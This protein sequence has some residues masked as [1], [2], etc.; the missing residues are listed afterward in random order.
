MKLLKPHWVSHD[1]NPIYSLS[2]HPDGT[3]IATGGQG[4]DSGIVV[5][6]NATPIQF[7]DSEKDGKVPKMLCELTNHLGCV[8]CVKWSTDGK[9]LASSGDDA[10]IMLWQLRYKGITAPAFGSDKPTH[11]QWG[12]GFM[13]R[14]HIGDVLDISWSQDQRFLASASVDNTI[15]VWNALKFPEKLATITEHTGLVKGLTWDP[16]GKYLASQSDDKSVRVWRTSDWKQEAKISAPFKNCGGTTHVLRLSWS[17]DGRFIVSA[18]SL[19]NDGP[20]AHI[21][22]RNSWKTGMD[23]VGHRKAIEVVSFNPHL[24]TKSDSEADNHGCIAIGSRDR[25]LSIWLTSLKRPLVVVH[26]LFNNSILDLAWSQ[27]GYTLMACSLDGTCSYMSFTKEEIGT[28]LEGEAIDDLFFDLYG[29]KRVTQDKVIDDLLLEDPAMLNVHESCSDAP[30]ASQPPKSDNTSSPS[31]NVSS[32]SSLSQQIE[33][34][35]KDGRRRI[36]PITLTGQPSSLPMQSTPFSS[37]KVCTT[38]KMSEPTPIKNQSLLSAAMDVR[39]AIEDTVTTPTQRPVK[40]PP[41]AHPISFA[42]LSPDHMRKEKIKDN[43][44]RSLSAAKAIITGAKRSNEEAGHSSPTLAKSKRSKRMR[45]TEDSM[46]SAK[47]TSAQ[48]KPSRVISSSSLLPT[49]GVEPSLS[50]LITSP[51]INEASTTI[52]ASNSPSGSTVS[53]VN[54]EGTAW[55]VSFSSPVLALSATHRVT[56]V[57]LEDSTAAFLSSL[58]G[59]CTCT[60]SIGYE[61]VQSAHNVKHYG[62]F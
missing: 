54:E 11:E 58:T 28:C 52:E 49:P 25:S 13:L 36:T 22:E 5:I 32:A 18:H 41:Q 33:T 17:P 39:G 57:C 23:F 4:K 46:P 1:G 55:T 6:W 26:E 20:T 48:Q 59:T 27:D 42:P 31:K 10:I 7:E 40:S 45:Q 14:G 16:V 60:G 12:C 9:W 19:N 30:Y 53:C 51:L 61:H 34:R 29:T 38:P 3:R 37:P 44:N 35:T 62:G 43:K 2:I 56:S 24:F 47:P 15:I 21:I 8:N 50:V